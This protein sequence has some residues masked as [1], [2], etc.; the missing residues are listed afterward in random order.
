[1]ETLNSKLFRFE[2]ST[3]KFVE[4]TVTAVNLVDNEYTLESSVNTIHEN[5][6]DMHKLLAHSHIE[7]NA[8]GKK[9]YSVLL[10]GVWFNDKNKAQEWLCLKLS[11]DISEEQKSLLNKMN[12]L[13][14]AL[15]DFDKFIK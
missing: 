15:C 12:K 4:Y 9:T 14:N 5:I 10:N 3:N 8:D 2:R 7:T 1:M 6:H 11:S 13:N